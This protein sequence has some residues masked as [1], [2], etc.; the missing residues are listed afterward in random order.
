M[1]EEDLMLL[2]IK[3]D[4]S[5]AITETRILDD[6]FKNLS[7]TFRKGTQETEKLNTV[8]A[9]QVKTSKDTKLASIDLNTAYLKTLAGFEAVTSA[10]NQ[11]ISAQYKKID[12]DLASGKITAEEAEAERKRIKQKEFYTGRLEELIAIMRLA[13]VGHMIYTSV[14]GMSST[15][16]VANT[17][18]VAANTLA[19]LANPLFWAIAGIVVGLGM[20][21]YALVKLAQHFKLLERSM[22]G[23]NSA[24]SFFKEGVQWITENVGE[25]LDSAGNFADRITGNEPVRRSI[26]QE[27]I[28]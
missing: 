1:A 20:M 25:A 22:E 7:T 6:N 10:T 8:M 4:A 15:A 19:L 18:A 12:A 26:E 14:V 24:I 11:Y 9:K 2:V 16:I 5:G 17:K 3:T 28:T 27:A 13:T 21:V 23:V